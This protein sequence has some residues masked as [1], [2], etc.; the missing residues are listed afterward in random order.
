MHGNTGYFAFTGRRLRNTP[1]TLGERQQAITAL[2]RRE[3]LDTPRPRKRPPHAA[4]APKQI[5]IEKNV[6]TK[7]MSEPKRGTGQNSITHCVVTTLAQRGPDRNRIYQLMQKN[8]LVQT[9]KWAERDDQYR[10]GVINAAI[11]SLRIEKE[12]LYY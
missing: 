7:W 11:E 12:E 5:L 9:S 6:S 4:L 1:A 3:F 8:P 10:W 2:Y